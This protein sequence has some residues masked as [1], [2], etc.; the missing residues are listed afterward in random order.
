L[1]STTDI[2]DEMTG[3]AEGVIRERLGSIVVD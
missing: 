2:I 1:I 3:G